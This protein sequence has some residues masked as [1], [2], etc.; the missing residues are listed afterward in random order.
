[1]ALVF[2]CAVAAFVVA[3][4]IVRGLRRRML[5]EETLR[6]NLGGEATPF[7]Y[8]AV[9]QALKQQKFCLQNE[10]QIER[11][12]A[13]LSEQIT[14]AVLAKLPCGIVFFSP[15]GLV[16]Q[17]NTAAR[18]ILGFASPLGMSVDQLFGQA[19]A[20]GESG[21][22]TIREIFN[23]S[24]RGEPHTPDFEICHRTPAGQL[25]VLNL[26]IVPLGSRD[27]EELGVAWVITDQSAMAGL[28]RAEI[29]RR[30][31]SRELA[32][33]LRTSLGTIRGYVEQICGTGD[34]STRVLAKVIAFE[35]ERL[36]RAVGGFLLEKTQE[37]AFAAHG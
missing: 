12:R 5:E 8:S 19:Q 22:P 9:I 13:K 15:N 6:D 27:G 3:V 24:L 23:H 25:R 26:V 29:L 10:Q 1:M 33:D 16:R 37:Q 35:T 21:T 7:P 4:V 34:Q 30:E 31:K 2:V 11:R 20:I 14:S 17:A 36:E 18:Q 32:L 28:C